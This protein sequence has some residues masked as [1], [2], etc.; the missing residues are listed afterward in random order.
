MLRYSI[1]SSVNAAF[2]SCC[3]PEQSAARDSYYFK[4]PDGMIFEYS[5]SVDE[6]EDEAARAGHGNS[7]QDDE[8]LYVGSKPAAVA[9]PNNST[10]DSPDR[11]K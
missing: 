11:A 2:Q 6:I 9:L 1:I 8:L 5:V 3:G 7:A 4:G 10:L